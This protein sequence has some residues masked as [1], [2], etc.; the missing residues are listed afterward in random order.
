MYLVSN[1]SRFYRL[2]GVIAMFA[3]LTGCGYYKAVKSLSP[4]EQN[5][6]RAYRKV[7]NGPQARTYLAKSNAAER[8]AYLREIGAA[9]CFAALNPQDQEAVLRGDIRK[10]MSAEALHFLWGH[11]RDTIGNPDE[12]AYWVYNGQIADLLAYGN[13]PS[14]A[15]TSVKVYFVDNQVEWW[16]E[17]VPES[18]DDPGD[19]FER[20][21]RR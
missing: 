13:R 2:L 14:D 10:G 15:G 8:Q 4:E 18:N 7:I 1:Q 9:Q 12:W 5:T 17:G 20:G 21:P 3:V 16:F 11:P 6:F 19:S